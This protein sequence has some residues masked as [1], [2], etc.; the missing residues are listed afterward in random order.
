[1]THVLE[2]STLECSTPIAV[3]IGF[4]AYDATFHRSCNDF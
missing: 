3:F 1:V 4:E 2:V